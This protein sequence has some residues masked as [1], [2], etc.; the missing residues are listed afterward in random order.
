MN[1]NSVACSTG[2]QWLRRIALFLIYS[3]PEQM[4]TTSVYY[5]VKVCALPTPNAASTV[6]Y[7]S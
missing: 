3:S 5:F 1:G 6:F 2:L 4:P 7:W